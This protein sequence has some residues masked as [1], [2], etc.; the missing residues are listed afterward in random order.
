MLRFV[1]SVV[2]A[3]TMLFLVGCDEYPSWGRQ[4]LSVSV[5]SG[6][7]HAEP[8]RTACFVV[9]SQAAYCDPSFRY[10][11]DWGDS[12]TSTS[13]LRSPGDT[14]VIKHPWRYPGRYEIWATAKIDSSSVS[15]QPSVHHTVVVWSDSYPIIDSAQLRTQ[16]Q[17][18]ALLAFVHNL[19][20]DSTRLAVA[21]GDGRSETTAF[22]TSPCRFDLTHIFVTHGDMKVVFKALGQSGTASAPETLTAS[23][24]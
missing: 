17:P 18:A 11:M 6:A 4:T 3:A 22:Q 21:W 16:Q 2:T 7:D 1:V 19:G 9:T 5:V 14:W 24:P 12:T 15:I 10:V 13:N 8:C 23:L 20:G